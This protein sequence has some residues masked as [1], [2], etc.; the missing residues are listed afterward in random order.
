MKWNKILYLK[1][2]EMMRDN[3]LSGFAGIS[4]DVTLEITKD[5]Y[6]Q[7][8]L[9]HE[10][11]DLYKLSFLTDPFGEKKVDSEYEIIVDDEK[12]TADVVA[13]VSETG[14]QYVDIRKVRQ[15]KEEYSNGISCIA[16]ANLTKYDGVQEAAENG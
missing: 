1:L 2:R 9:K 5:E 16:V 14:K 3:L 15:N 6:H 13:F 11:G 8:I 10:K 12:A 4:G 7:M